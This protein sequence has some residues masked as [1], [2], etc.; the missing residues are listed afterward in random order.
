MFGVLRVFFGLVYC[1]QWV[2][3]WQ[4]VSYYDDFKVINVGV[5]LV[6]I[7]GLG[8]DIDGKL[9]LFVGG[10]GKGVDFY[11]LCELV[12]C[13]CWVVVL[14]GCDVG[15]IV[16]VLGNVVLLVC[17]VM[18]DEV[19]WQVVELV[20]EGDVVLLLLVCVSLDMFKNFEECGCLFVKVVEELV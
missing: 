19:V 5:V 14:F 6:V 8:V 1:C 9:V 11:D 10:D 17:V 13:F 7:E 20:C 15:L 4:G 12:V 16:Q 18:L 3:E 2:C